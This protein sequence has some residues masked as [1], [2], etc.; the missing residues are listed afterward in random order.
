MF[1]VDTAHSGSP[2]FGEG[3]GGAKGLFSEFKH[4][5]LNLTHSLVK[6]IE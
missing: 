3:G 2:N 6:F 5:F 4:T 1:L